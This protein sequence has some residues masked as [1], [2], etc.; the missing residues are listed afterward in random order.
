MHA[1]LTGGMLTLKRIVI[2]DLRYIII[3]A[4]STNVVMLVK[5]LRRE[6]EKKNDKRNFISFSGVFF[7]CFVLLCTHRAHRVRALFSVTTLNS[8]S[9]SG[10]LCVRRRCEKDTENHYFFF[11][12]SMDPKKGEESLKKFFFCVFVSFTIKTLDKSKILS[13]L[14]N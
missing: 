6:I 5:T 13:Q 10:T 11:F 3:E 14:W 4:H 9:C 1:F 2:F 8:F 12:L 7:A